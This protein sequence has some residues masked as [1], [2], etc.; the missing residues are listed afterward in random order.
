MFSTSTP[1]VFRLLVISLAVALLAAFA[2][3]RGAQ[4]PSESEAKKLE[5]TK[6]QTQ[7]Y[8]TKLSQLPDEGL[9]RQGGEP[10]SFDD[11]E[12]TPV[13]LSA[14]YT[15]CPME[16]MCPLLTQKVGQVQKKLLDD[17]EVGPRDFHVVLLTFDPE[18]DSPDD[19]ESYAEERG[20]IAE[21]ADFVSGESEAISKL[22]ESIEVAVTEGE[23]G[24]FQH[25]MRTYLTDA[26]DRIYS[27]FRQA[28]WDPGDVVDRFRPAIEGQ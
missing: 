12:G 7:V 8:G 26:S 21:N 28:K 10:F 16:K 25:N 22:M 11:L 17:S 5:L 6:V 20:V 2:C 18:R 3:E 27:G 9:Q 1:H 14:I 13:I 4:P 15:N 24:T 19:V 23:D